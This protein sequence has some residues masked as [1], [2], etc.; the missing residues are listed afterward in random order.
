MIGG[1]GA[2]PKKQKIAVVGL[3]NIGRIH[4]RSYKEHPEAE[5][6]AVCDLNRELTDQAARMFGAKAYYDVSSML[7]QED[8]DIVSVATGG[9]E[10]G[11]HHYAPAMAAISAGKSVLVEKPLSNDLGEAREMVSFA[12]EQGVRLGC[13]LNHRFTPMALKAKQWID[14]GE[15]GT[16]LFVNMK[17]TIG[18]PKESSPWLH[19]RA[20]HPHSFDVLR[21]FAGDVKRVQAFMTKAPG[22]SVW[23][24]AS[25][26]LEFASGAVGHLMGSYDMD[27]KHPIESCEVAGQRGRFLLDNV[28]EALTLYRHGQEELSV[29]RNPVLGGFAGFD[30]TFRSRLDTFIRQVQAEVPPEQIEASGADGLAV[31]SLIEAAIQSQENGGKVIELTGAS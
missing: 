28:Y 15:L 5:L 3:N 11:S 31:Q 6:V 27:N 14:A 18:N 26:N 2:M 20:L 30:G 21:Y 12:K 8:I 4:C 1:D 29:Y 16:L 22:R 25:I 10:N 7:E 17:L 13:N 23:S 24:T 9:V 19:M